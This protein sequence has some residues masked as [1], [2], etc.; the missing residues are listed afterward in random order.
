MTHPDQQSYKSAG[1]GA[2]LGRVTG[3]LISHQAVTRRMA[4]NS[5]LDTYW[6]SQR[7]GLFVNAY[8]D[9]FCHLAHI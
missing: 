8:P 5:Y 7:D 3:Y 9:A 2:V 1:I 4:Q 6:C